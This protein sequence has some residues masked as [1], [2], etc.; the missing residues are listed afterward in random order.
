[1][2]I[3]EPTEVEDTDRSTDAEGAPMPLPSADAI[4]SRTVGFP[5]FD[6]YDDLRAE[7]AVYDLTRDYLERVIEAEAVEVG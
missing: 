1:M 5:A 4:A 6:P 7:L 3:H 2:S